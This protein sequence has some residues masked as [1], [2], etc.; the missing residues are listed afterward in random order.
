MTG[1]QNL[2]KFVSLFISTII[3]PFHLRQV[4]GFKKR[5]ESNNNRNNT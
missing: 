4:K 3:I 5:K 2:R 1:S